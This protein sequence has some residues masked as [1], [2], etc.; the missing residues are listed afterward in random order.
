MAGFTTFWSFR[1][2]L[3]D[4]ASRLAKLRGAEEL[5]IKDADSF[6][7]EVANKVAALA[8]VSA[9]HPLSPQLAVGTV[10]R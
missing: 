5:R 7:T 2:E 8:G 4:T 6:F 3:G 1:G 10:K 9:A